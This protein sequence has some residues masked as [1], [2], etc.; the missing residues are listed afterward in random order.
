MDKKAPLGS[1]ILAVLMGLRGLM[2]I[3]AVIALTAGGL[4]TVLENAGYGNLMSTQNLFVGGILSIVY[5]VGAV[6]VF[7]ANQYGWWV[8]IIWAIVEAIKPISQLFY[9]GI[10][11]YTGIFGLIVMALIFWYLLKNKTR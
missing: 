2:G 10:F 9:G 3:I 6:L 7:K 8:L 1:K 11:I 5:L 4:L